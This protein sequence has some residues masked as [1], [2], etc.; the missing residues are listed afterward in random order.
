MSLEHGLALKEVDVFLKTLA[1]ATRQIRFVSRG[2]NAYA[3]LCEAT[4]SAMFCGLRAS[5]F[6]RA[7]PSFFVRPAFRTSPPR[8]EQ[9]AQTRGVSTYGGVHLFLGPADPP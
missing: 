1:G 4:P 7:A 2:G 8:F 6:F 3:I 5:F 9:G